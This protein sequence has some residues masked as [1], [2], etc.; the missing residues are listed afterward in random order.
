MINN[1][2]MAEC[3][4]VETQVGGFGKNIVIY[5]F[6]NR[7]DKFIIGSDNKMTAGLAGGKDRMLPLKQLI[8]F[9]Q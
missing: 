8:L 3:T 5:D 4:N 9:Y 2:V 7:I 6:M 1:A